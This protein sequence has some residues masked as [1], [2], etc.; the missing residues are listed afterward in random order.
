MKN[1]DTDDRS[2]A[3]AYSGN[4][5]GNL[6]QLKTVFAFHKSLTTLGVNK[7]ADNKILDASAS[8]HFTYSYARL[9]PNN[10]VAK[11]N[12]QPTNSM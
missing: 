9:A 4:R 8:F 10:Q 3:C 1:A 5:K 11:P 7:T 12:K 2:D 6:F